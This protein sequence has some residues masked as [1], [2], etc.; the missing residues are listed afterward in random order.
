MGMAED[1]GPHRGC[2]NLT[3]ATPGGE[4]MNSFFGNPG[5]YAL[6]LATTYTSSMTRAWN[7][8]TLALV[9]CFA[10]LILWELHHRILHRS[11]QNPAAAVPAPAMQLEPLTMLWAWETP[12]DLTALDRSKTGVAFLSRELLIGR[13]VQI[14][15]RRQ[16]LRLATNTWLMAVVRI[17]TGS[18]FSPNAN[19]I[20]ETAHDIAAVAQ[21]PNVRAIQ[22]DFDVTASQRTFYAAVLTQLRPQLPPGMPLSITALVG[23]C[24]DDSWL[25]GLPIDE[26]VPMFFRMGGPA[27]TR[28][29]RPKDASVVHEPLCSGS[30]GI[31]T[32]ETWPAIHNRERVY[33]FLPGSW[34]QQDIAS[35]N[36][37]GY[38]G[39][40]GVPHR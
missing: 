13:T 19:T 26:A 18:D 32:D 5:G 35:I 24:G 38:H 9:A 27:T 23:W 14:R 33:V 6:R 21:Q 30:A 25:H 3:F 1:I 8:W 7:Q 11:H 10:I 37:L 15:P 12:E 34:T 16:P 4:E 2:G 29:I 28:A 17:E 39:L 40:T 20:T 36:A 31:A 22:V